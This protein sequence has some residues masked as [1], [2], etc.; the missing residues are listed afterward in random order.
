M[1]PL[2][3]HL[4]SPTSLLPL[5]IQPESSCYL[6]E[7]SQS[8][9]INSEKIPKKRLVSHYPF[10]TQL[11]LFLAVKNWKERRGLPTGK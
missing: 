8:K 2:Q 6:Q 9:S 10:F 1:S 7:I 3:N 5:V 4:S 11:Q